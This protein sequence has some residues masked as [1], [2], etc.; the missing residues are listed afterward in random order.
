MNND[1]YVM[2]RLSVAEASAA[3][4]TARQASDAIRQRRATARSTSLARRHQLCKDR[5]ERTPIA[6]H[7]RT[8]HVLRKVPQVPGLTRLDVAQRLEQE[9][10]H[11]VHQGS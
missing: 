5:T 2:P 8:F 9:H 4:P 11:A 10:R 3:R 6:R 7:A 1:G